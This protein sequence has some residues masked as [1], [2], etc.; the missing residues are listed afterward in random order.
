M[1]RQKLLF[2]FR[3][4]CFNFLAVWCNFSLGFCFSSF[5]PP[6]NITT[7]IVLILTINLSPLSPSSSTSPLVFHHHHHR[8][9][10]QSFTNITILLILTDNL[11]PSSISAS[12]VV[13]HHPQFLPSFN[14]VFWDNFHLYMS[15][16]VRMK[17][18]DVC[19]KK[20]GKCGNFS[21]FGD[22]PPPSLGTPSL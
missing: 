21:Q 22:S 11:S 12:P 17:M 14:Y 7:T 10:H 16:N 18:R 9:H 4:W 20:T 6:P 19:K 3:I 13:I 8:P 1:S 2:T 5:W 15:I